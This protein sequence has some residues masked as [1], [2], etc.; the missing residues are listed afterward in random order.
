MTFHVYHT[1][2]KCADSE[3]DWYLDMSG[4]LFFLEDGGMREAER[5]FYTDCYYSINARFEVYTG[6]RKVTDK[7]EWY[8][9]MDGTLFYFE[10]GV[11]RRAG[12]LYGL[13]VE[14]TDMAD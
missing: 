4:S 12:D 8:A 5:G 9:G 11:V 7:K 6:G 3:R 1:D 10:D 2:G 14:E 13:L